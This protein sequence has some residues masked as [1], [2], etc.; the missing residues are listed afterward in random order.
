MGRYKAVF[1]LYIFFIL[2]F[3]AC[4][5][6]EP[7]LPSWNVSLNIPLAKKIYSLEDLVNNNSIN[8][9][10]DGSNKN[11]LYF[12]KSISLD[13]IKFE[14]KL[15]ID[16]IS[17]TV[18]ESIE[19]ISLLPDTLQTEIG[20]DW[21]GFDNIPAMP[22]S[23]APVYNEH[24][25]I[26]TDVSES[27]ESA[28]IQSGK[29]D[30]EIIN[31]LPPP[32]TLTISHILLKSI[33]TGETLL[34]IDDDI[35]IQHG[36]SIKINSL[37]LKQ[38]VRISNQFLFE[39]VLSTNGTGGEEVLLPKNSLTVKVKIEDLKVLEA[40]AKI[41][42]QVPITIED[43]FTLDDN[44]PLP[45]KLS[46]LRIENGNINLKVANKLDLDAK[47]HLIIYNLRKPDGQI[48]NE[49]RF[50][51]RKQTINVFKDFSL[52]D[53]SLIGSEGKPSN[54]FSYKITVEVA[55]TDDMRT[56]KSNDGI[57][58]YVD[59]Q[60]L[61]VKEFTGK[62]KPQKISADKE[63]VA[64]NL[65]EFK[66]KIQFQKI[67]FRNILL[68]LAFQNTA[69][70]EFKIDGKL[71]AKNKFGEKA[72]LGLNKNTLSN[73]IISPTDTLITFNKDSLN[74]FLNKFTRLPDS[75]IIYVDGIINPNYKT[76][77]VRN[78]D[79]I[80]TKAIIDL[81][82]DVSIEN[83]EYRDSINI[84]L[85]KDDK[86]KLE[87]INS[88]SAGIKVINRLPVSL[89]L[90]CKFY[91]EQN[92]FLTHFPPLYESQDTT[93]TITGALVDNEGF[94]TTANEQLINVNILKRDID[95]VR[96]AKYVILFIK[97]NTSDND[98]PVKFL[99][100]DNFSVDLYCSTDYN[101]K[102]Q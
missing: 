14:D 58:A 27:F 83:I 81:P 97:I 100:S 98:K 6:N 1:I 39:C 34:N 78:T 62:I 94:V 26:T 32:F 28:L 96:K 50:I 9:Y 30:L 56:I 8:F 46:L 21:L 74:L 7:N 17:D 47:V 59:L 93:F 22:V 87:N 88:I 4:Q 2:I 75:I 37:Q 20:L 35:I 67:N 76:V 25:S 80:L 48:F 51:G 15:T 31:H 63:S 101:V 71:E 70:V 61:K 54:S 60:N 43:T 89:K 65:D 82:L 90:T 92:N 52:K 99:T 3:Q 44:E 72:V 49:T 77:T 10:A 36:S 23:V 79:I 91:D 40:R 53:Y 33:S 68:R 11:L 24:I 41:P 95:K 55:S 13:T 19:S 38:G 42:F 66:N 5:I 18:S 102:L 29:V 85:S 64:L 86:D 73:D 57:T 16:N 12:S 45:S 84:N 69:Q